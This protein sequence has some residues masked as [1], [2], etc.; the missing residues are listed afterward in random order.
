MQTNL[1]LM[2]KILLSLTLIGASFISHS[3]VI[4]AGISPA[5]IAGNYDFTWADPAGGDWAC[6]DFLTTGVYIQGDLM[7][8]DDGSVGN[9]PISGLPHANYGC[10]P[11]INNLTGKIAVV[12]RYDGS[13]TS[14]PTYCDFAVKALNAQTAGAIGVIIINRVPGV[15]AM[16]G[17]V[18]GINVTIP[19]VML[20]DSDG[21]NLRAEMQNG[22]VNM[23]I[24]NKVG[25][26]ADDAGGLPGTT[27]IS[28]SSGV[29]SQLATNATEFNFELGTRVYN[30]GFN[31]QANVT[32]TANID[33]PSGSS[34]YVNTVGP[35][36]IVSLDSVD[37]YPGGTYSFPQF[38]LDSYPAGRYTL[39]YTINIGTT[40]MYASDN[41]I[42]SEFVVNDSI[43]GY[44]TMDA[45]T[46]LP[47]ANNGYRPSTNTSTFSTC[48]VIDNPNASRIGVEGMYFQ[49]STSAA[50]G[51][52]L[53]GEEMT[54]NLYRWE[55]VFTDL[56]DAALAFTTLNPIAFGYYYY[57]SDLQ[58]EMV[59]GAFNVPV[60]LEDN[61]RFLAC[62]QTVNLEVFLGHDTKS[63][64]LWN[65][66]YYLQ[67]L[68]P[69]ESDG[70]Y[71][72]VGFGMD[73]PS[74]MGLKVFD[75]AEL[76]IAEVGSLEG[77]AYPNPATDIVTVSLKA[78]G[79]ASLS[80]TDVSGK[81]ALNSTIN[82]LNGK[83]E[84]AI[85]SLEAGMYVFNIVTEG[86]QTSQF[87][88]VKK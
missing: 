52:L 31:D 78:E 16:G 48:M 7:L 86:G 84:I 68:A 62:V 75:A 10:A 39:T 36:S 72:A 45:V 12:Y 32:V 17:S 42:T 61:Q 85:S 2:K 13:A 14:S 5:P 87:N 47:V 63:N 65:E 30:Y 8:V 76:G 40:D 71:F 18:D 28:K 3:Q 6:P 67:P 20:S 11:L 24:G 1:K 21:A 64:Y 55:D 34:I 27:L 58:S 69:N 88:V 80:I 56:N 4:C 46:N 51:V 50:S 53:T 66:A 74:A 23:F 54:L 79:N 9:S 15:L 70:T 25:L 59:Y 26:F 44:A 43:Y 35:F 29:L 77:V 73:T 57:P 81:V 49:A 60:L 22:P 38:S 33:G 83:A 41:V 82:L 37:V 19:V